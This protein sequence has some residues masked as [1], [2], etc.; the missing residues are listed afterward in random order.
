MQSD[1]PSF[2]VDTEKSTQRQNYKL[3]VGQS[4][5]IY[6]DRGAMRIRVICENIYGAVHALASPRPSVGSASG[7]LTPA[8]DE[9]PELSDFNLLQPGLVGPSV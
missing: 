2:A 4:S 3:V 5:K 7:G 9:V 6:N 1:F 8:C